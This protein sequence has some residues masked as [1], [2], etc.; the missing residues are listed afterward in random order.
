MKSRASVTNRFS[1]WESTEAG[2]LP[3]HRRPTPRISRG[4]Q[5]TTQHSRH[6]ARRLHPDS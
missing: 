5:P 6:F 3:I 4:Q 1:S 2:I